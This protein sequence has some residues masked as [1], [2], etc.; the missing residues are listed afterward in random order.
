MAGRFDSPFFIHPDRQ[1]KRYLTNIVLVLL[2]VSAWACSSSR[3][4]I[5]KSDFPLMNEYAN[6]TNEE[7]SVKIPEGWLAVDENKNHSI[8]LWLVKEDFSATISFTPI[9]VDDS[10]YDEIKSSESENDLSLALDY[11]KT[12]RKAVL[13][14]KFKPV[15]KDEYFELDNRP[16]AAYQFTDSNSLPARVVVFR[17]GRFYYEVSANFSDKKA[18]GSF[19]SE[20]LFRVQNSILSTLK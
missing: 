19:S 3:E 9:H 17:Y 20:E 1:M 18:A 6:S 12:F 15:L 16:F 13:G 14:D 7:L 8:D 4:S 5:Y 11:S 10:T 2:M